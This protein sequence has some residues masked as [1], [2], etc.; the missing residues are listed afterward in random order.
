VLRREHRNP[1]SF[2]GS[3]LATLKMYAD[4]RKDLFVSAQP[5]EPHPI[6]HDPET[7]LARL[8]DRYREIFLA[9]YR[10]A[11]EAAAHQVWKWKHLGEVLHMWHLRSVA[12][13]QPG[14]EQAKNDA[15]AGVSVP[16]E[17]LIPGWADLVANRT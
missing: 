16:A 9:D 4:D 5:V 1:V 6:E 15:L 14:Y 10:S 8:P 12:Y 13:T 2:I 17:D 7:I 3:H 11:M